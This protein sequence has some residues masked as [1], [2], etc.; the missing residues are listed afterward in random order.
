MLWSS[1]W[2]IC[3]VSEIVCLVQI[4]VLQTLSFVFPH[5]INFP[6]IFFNL[7]RPLIVLLKRQCNAAFSSIQTSY[8]SINTLFLC[9]ESMVLFSSL[10]LKYFSI[11]DFQVSSFNI[12]SGTFPLEGFSRLNSDVL[13]RP[14]CNITISNFSLF[15]CTSVLLLC[16]AAHHIAGSLCSKCSS[17][18]QVLENFTLFSFIGPYSSMSWLFKIE[19]G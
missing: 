17:R 16:F 15:L 14:P 12:C 10:S 9:V 2:S 4:L 3:G 5:N 1:L 11:N 6:I 8:W 19:F 18:L 7:K 13:L